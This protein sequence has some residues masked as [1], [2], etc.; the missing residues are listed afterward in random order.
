MSPDST[1]SACLLLPFPIHKSFLKPILP[2]S[3]QGVPVLR[4]FPGGDCGGSEPVRG[5]CRRFSPCEPNTQCIYSKWVGTTPSATCQKFPVLFGF[6]PKVNVSPS[7][8]L[9]NWSQREE[10]SRK[11]KIDTYYPWSQR[12]SHLPT[13]YAHYQW[14]HL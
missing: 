2:A 14:A 3:C 5:S 12:N 9:W 11:W 10:T 1:P 6:K 13:A 4:K 8:E 7:R